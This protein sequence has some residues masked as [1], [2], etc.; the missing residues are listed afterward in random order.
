MSW[1]V[2][3][4]S[5]GGPLGGPRTA[6]VMVANLVTADSRSANKLIMGTKKQAMIVCAPTAAARLS[7]PRRSAASL[8]GS[9][10]RVWGGG[11][12]TTARL[13]CPSCDC[14]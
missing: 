1:G 8:P 6:T 10:Q 12:R 9:P 14:R 4:G 7:A 3:W 5:A 11:E 2:R 13:P